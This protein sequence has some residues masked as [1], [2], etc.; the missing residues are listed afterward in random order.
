M[1]ITYSSLLH[2]G[3]NRR[4]LLLYQKH[5]GSCGEDSAVASC[6]CGKCRYWEIK[7][8]LTLQVSTTGFWHVI[9]NHC[10]RIPRD[11]LLNELSM[12]GSYYCK[13]LPNRWLLLVLDT[14]EMSGHS[15]FPQVKSRS[16]SSHAASVSLHRQPHSTLCH[17]SQAFA[18]LCHKLTVHCF[19]QAKL[20]LMNA[21]YGQDSPIGQETIK[22]KAQHPLS[23]EEPQMSDW[24]GGLASAQLHWLKQ[25]LAQA[26][27]RQQRVIVACHHQIGKGVWQRICSCRAAPCSVSVCQICLSV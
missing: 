15:N 25:Q 26:A 12:P 6:S 3:R 4:G 21:C 27:S 14:T 22:F 18:Q 8:L 16:C 10:L 9:G 24:N 19:M 20:T 5:T 23:A 13:Q 17:A 2:V 7:M 1:R 11:R